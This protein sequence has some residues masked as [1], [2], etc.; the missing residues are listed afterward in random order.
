MLNQL[1]HPGAPRFSVFNGRSS[2]GRCDG[3]LFPSLTSEGGRT[4]SSHPRRLLLGL[5]WLGTLFREAAYKDHSLTGQAAHCFVL[6][7]LN[8]VL[9]PSE[10]P[11][12]HSRLS[13]LERDL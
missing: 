5:C 7:G 6:G 8:P 12:G 3:F 11:R 13:L 1:S 4:A 2:V 10:F 9:G